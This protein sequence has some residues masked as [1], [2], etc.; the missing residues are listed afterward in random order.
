MDDNYYKNQMP[1]VDP[2][3][4]DSEK[5]KRM[6]DNDCQKSENYYDSN[7]CQSYSSENQYNGN[8]TGGSQYNSN[9]APAYNNNNSQFSSPQQTYS[10]SNNISP[11]PK[12]Y[13]EDYTVNYDNPVSNRHGINNRYSTLSFVFGLS[14]LM[15]VCFIV[16]S[17]ILSVFGLVYGIKTLK[18]NY[19]YK[20]FAIAGIILSIISFVMVLVLIAAIALNQDSIVIR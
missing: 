3:D 16:I 1:D 10:N 20:G 4:Y 12:K 9:P 17:V 19:A 5:Y 6:K 7:R 18:N 15:F 14:S 8:Q 11:Q 13:V 2:W